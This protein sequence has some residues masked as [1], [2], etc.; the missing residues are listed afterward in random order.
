VSGART[1]LDPA[2]Q[3]TRIEQMEADILLKEQPVRLAPRRV[4]VGFM[5]A[6]AAILADAFTGAKFF[7]GK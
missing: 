7:L 6:V 1:S 5:T 4:V 2:A 3:L